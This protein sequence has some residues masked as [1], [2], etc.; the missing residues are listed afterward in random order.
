MIEIKHLSKRYGEIEAVDDVNFSVEEGEVFCLLGSNGAGKT[1]I[2]KILTG[3]L[4]ATEGTAL[5]DG[6][7]VNDDVNLKKRFGYL[8]EQPHLY[9]RLTGYEFLD[10]MG[11]LKGVE[12]N[13]LEKK[14]DRYSE[15]LE[16]EDRIHSEMGAYSKGMKQ[17]ILFINAILH[18]PPNFIL[19]EPTVGLDPRY[20]QYMKRKI[21]EFSKDGKTVL[22]TTHITSVAEEIADKVGIIGKGKLLV[23]GPIEDLKTSTGTETLEQTFVE[24]IRGGK[25]ST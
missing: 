5:I 1:T 9:D 2:I 7:E 23:K 19:D 13:I 25:G 3:L 17:K 18:D 21:D 12:K 22:M 14:I 8:P 15:E 16:L 10:T 4:E 11:S 24:V 6:K 20:A